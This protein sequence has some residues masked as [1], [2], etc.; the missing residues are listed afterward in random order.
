MSKLLPANIDVAKLTRLEAQGWFSSLC[1]DTAREEGTDLAKAWTKIKLLYPALADKAFS[2]NQAGRYGNG[3]EL[4]APPRS[5]QLAAAP[6]RGAANR[7]GQAP[8]LASN[9]LPKRSAV[10]IPNEGTFTD[11][12]RAVLIDKGVLFPADGDD[13]ILPALSKLFFRSSAVSRGQ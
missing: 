3:A 4:I 9:L 6:A 8:S 11:R 13:K 12:V 10:S 1:Q 5:A 7:V 2:G